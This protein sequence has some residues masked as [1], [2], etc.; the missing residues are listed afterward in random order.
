MKKMITA[1]A[2]ALTGLM[3]AS[4]MAA[5][6]DRYDERHAHAQ[7]GQD[8]RWNSHD[9]GYEHQRWNDGRVNPSR[10]WR[11]GQT[12]PRA[13]DAPRYKV[14]SREVRRLPDTGRYQQW[15][16]INGDYVLVNERNHRILRI[17]G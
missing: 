6:D 7:H 12:L 10:H 11:I 16:R 1:A 2:L 14:S 9:R 3:A 15:Y 17:I 4:A 13:F 8:G 5:P